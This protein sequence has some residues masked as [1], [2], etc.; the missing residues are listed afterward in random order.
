MI[1]NKLTSLILDK[2]KTNFF[3]YGFGQVFNLLS[4]L[5]V[6]PKI[7]S[8]CGEAGFGK[9]G[10]AFALCLFLMLIVDYAFDI[11]GTKEVSEN[12]NNN[13]KLQEILNTAIFTKLIL[14]VFTLFVS[15]ILIFSLDFFNQ[16]KNLFLFAIT[17]VFAQVF[18]PVWF[19][20]GLENFKLVS[21]LNIISKTLYVIL[22]FFLINKK[23]DYVFVNLF[24]GLSSLTLN[25]LGLIL[26]KKKFNF[27]V[28]LPDFS[29]VKKIIQNDFSFCVSQLSLSVRQL[30]PLVLTS[31]FLG[32]SIAGQYKIIEQII[33]LCRTFLQVFLKF[34]YPSACFK[35]KDSPQSGLLYWKKYTLICIVIITTFLLG[36]LLFSDDVLRFFQLSNKAILQ[37]SLLFKISL[38]I[39]LLMSISLPLEQLMFIKEKHAKYIKTTIF[40]TLVNVVLIVFFVNQFQLK[41]IIFSL[42]LAELLFI[43]FYYIFTKSTLKVKF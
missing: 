41:A 34:F 13:Q 11:K 31:F 23:N 4:P 26:I 1:K 39:S 27:Q 38:I 25:F 10:L 42:I 30:S 3:I 21:I 32:F 16:E 36:I 24:L 19:L 28:V 12:R 6:A 29:V 15:L 14:F 17:I 2:K 35:Y 20:Q 7:I 9:V 37:L 40:V 5:V 43:I 8:I 18:N 22:V 33:S